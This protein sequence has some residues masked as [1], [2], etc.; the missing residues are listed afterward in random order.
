M[1]LIS[2]VGRKDLRIKFLLITIIGFLWL[3]IFL[4]LF[5]VWWIFISSIKSAREV[6]QFPPT[7]WPR[8]LSFAPYKL[9]FTL[10][11]GEWGPVQ[12]PFH[13]YLKN[14]LIITGVTIAIQV[15]TTAFLAYY[16][17]K[18]C[19][20]KISRFLFLFC[21]G[22]MM[23]PAQIS[24]IPSYLI[25]R[26]FP[27]PFLNIPKIPFTNS[28]FPTINFIDTY[29]AVILPATYSAFNI[30][31]FKGF[32]DGIPN[33]FINAARLDGASEIGIFRR[34][35][36]PVSKP[37]FAV[38]SYLTFS[39]VWNAFLWPLI[40]IKKNRLQPL[41]VFMYHLQFELQSHPLEG[42][43]P[44]SEGLRQAGMGYNGL[45]ALSILQ[46]IPVFIIFII[47]REQ[48]MTGIRLRGFK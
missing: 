45:M 2:R 26:H 27:F 33:E 4:H 29:W 11:S 35:I 30:L 48:L 37:V 21:I 28:P 16:L 23:L 19:P 43:D 24:L 20:L 44:V 22:T 31:L 38:V 25:I 8:E 34:I 41:S 9:I 40:V 32:F 46:S 17:S 1:A 6:L 47:F 39:G 13:I 15:P 7:F 3:G 36:L 12:S 18:L 5:P 10:A 42:F 14:S